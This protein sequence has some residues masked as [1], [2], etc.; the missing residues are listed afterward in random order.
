MAINAGGFV[1]R[2]FSQWAYDPVWACLAFTFS[3][4]AANHFWMRIKHTTVPY[5]PMR[6]AFNPKLEH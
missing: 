5:D 1:P 3:Y 4:V 2:K 6:Y